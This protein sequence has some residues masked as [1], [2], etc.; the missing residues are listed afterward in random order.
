VVLV[1]VIVVVVVVV[2]GDKSFWTFLLGNSFG[3]EEQQ[4]LSISN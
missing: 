3:K 2:V 4:Q 1:V